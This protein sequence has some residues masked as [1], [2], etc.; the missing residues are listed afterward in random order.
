MCH[1]IQHGAGPFAELIMHSR[2]EEGV[3]VFIEQY[4][5]AA[6]R[7]QQDVAALVNA[8]AQYHSK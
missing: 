3:H 8:R 4:L 7:C 2:W 1:C 6:D 5:T